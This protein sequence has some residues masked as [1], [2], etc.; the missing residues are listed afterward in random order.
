MDMLGCEP[1]CVGSVFRGIDDCGQCAVKI[2]ID[3]A[4]AA[5]GL[6][7]DGSLGIANAG[8]AAA[9]AAVNAEKM[10]LLCHADMRCQNHT[11]I[12]VLCQP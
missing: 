2:L 6:G 12:V 8:A 10:L 7:Q 9:A 1:G 4:G 5:R 3:V 11:S